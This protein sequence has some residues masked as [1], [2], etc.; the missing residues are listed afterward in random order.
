VGELRVT[1]QLIDAYGR[2]HT[3]LRV[4]VIDKCNLRCT[5]CMPAEGVAWLPKPELLTVDE[6][7]RIVGI[8]TDAGVTEVRLTGGEPLLRADLVDIVAGINAL[9]TP[10]VMSL[11]TN[12]MRLAR[13]ADALA[14]AGLRRVNV[15]LDTL[16]D[17]RFFT[18]SRRTGLEQ[19]LEG[20]DA[21]LAAGLSPVKVNTV[22][23]RGVNDDEAP[24]LLKWALDTGVEIRFIEQMPLDAQH[25]WRRDQMVTTQDVIDMLSEHFTL[26][27]V[28]EHTHDPA[29]RHYVDGGP[30]TVGFISSVSAPFCG[31]CDRVRLTADGQFR[32]CLFAQVETDLRNPMRS[33]AS[34]D[35]VLALMQGSVAAKAAGH[36]INNPDFLQPPRPMSAI[37]G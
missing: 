21:A 23:M 6:I 32:N 17:E 24:R 25:A 11:T 18:L 19:V 3:D 15:S 20:I 22:L 7:V 35:E 14:D 28:E 36:G 33:G 2:V 13:V 12:G 10:P 8:A 34:D 1:P 26:T 9:P 27:A 16:D 37:G 29:R 5:Y 4:S 30:A 31:G